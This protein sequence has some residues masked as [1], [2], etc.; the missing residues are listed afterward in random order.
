MEPRRLLT[1]NVG[2][3]SLKAILYRVQPA[4]SVEV[5]ADAE[6]IGL[7]QSSLCIR[8]ASGA[9]LYQ[10]LDPIPDQTS[11]LDL[12]LDW[13]RAQR[14]DSGLAAV[15]QRIV[16][17]G[18]EYSA[19]TMITEDV[20]ATLRSLIPLD[21]EHLPQALQVIE[22]VSRAYPAIPQVAC[23]DTAFHRS[24][25]RVAQIY[26]L[27]RELWGA[28]VTRYGFHGLSYEYILEE[29]RTIDSEAADGRIV[30]AHRDMGRAWPLCTTES[31]SIRQ[32]GS[33]RS[34]DS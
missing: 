18:R 6:R 15:G 14:L 2:S 21:T 27:P 22:C 13:L 24:M 8:D 16:H 5:R 32:W 29:L 12:L 26:P 28:G 7:P 30:I 34:V 3:S 10:H 17:G 4:E 11:A 9:E 33:R 31:V 23:F 25:P 1:I 20:I 19:P